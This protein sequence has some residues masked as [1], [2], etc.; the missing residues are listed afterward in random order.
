MEAGLFVTMLIVFYLFLRYITQE[1]LPANEGA[2]H[3]NGL[4]LTLEV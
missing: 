2:I 4:A 3:R 1:R